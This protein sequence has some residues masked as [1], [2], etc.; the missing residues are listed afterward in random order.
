MEPLPE[1]ERKVELLRKGVGPMANV[2]LQVENLRE[3]F[4]QSVLSRGDRRLSP[5][6]AAMGEGKSLKAAARETGID[7]EWYAC[8]QIPLDE[9][10]PWEIIAAAD[11]GRLE[12]E[13]RR[14]F[15]V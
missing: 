7:A 1:L 11:R 12:E 13:Y 8:R 9:P 2:K 4:L 3:A 14:A 5:L 10:L 6:V 15:D